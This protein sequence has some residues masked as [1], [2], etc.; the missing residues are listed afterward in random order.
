M[1]LIKIKPN[2]P[3]YDRAF[4]HGAAFALFLYAFVALGFHDYGNA[5]AALGG[6]VAMLLV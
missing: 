6:A 3:A 5:A 1:P 2:D 4:K